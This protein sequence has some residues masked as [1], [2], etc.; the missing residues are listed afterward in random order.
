MALSALV[1]W[2][3]PLA[4]HCASLGELGDEAV[5]SGACILTALALPGR[6]PGAQ[7]VVSAQ[8]RYAHSRMGAVC[9]S[10]RRLQTF[11]SRHGNK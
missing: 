1:G 7:L 5:G 4:V 11:A 2:A 3:A 6:C 10:E 9:V 8:M